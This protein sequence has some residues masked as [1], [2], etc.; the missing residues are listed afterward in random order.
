MKIYSYDNKTKWYTKVN[1]ITT[2]IK[3][4]IA[5]NNLFKNIFNTIEKVYNAFSFDI[6]T[7]SLNIK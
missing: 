6:D 4:L 1:W 5:S 3:T 2:V 7:V